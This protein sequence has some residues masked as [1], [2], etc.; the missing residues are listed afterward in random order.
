[1]KTL[2][3]FDAVISKITYRRIF[4]FVAGI[5]ICYLFW[6]YR[7]EIMNFIIKIMKRKKYTT[8]VVI[9]DEITVKRVEQYIVA[10]KQFYKGIEHD[11]A[12][13]GMTDSTSIIYN[14]CKDLDSVGGYP[15][16]DTNFNVTGSVELASIECKEVKQPAPKEAQNK[17]QSDNNNQNKQSN[18]VDKNKPNDK[19][20]SKKDEKCETQILNVPDRKCI[21]LIEICCLMFQ[22]KNR[23]TRL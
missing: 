18:D 10:H 4:A 7:T 15:F 21:R 2:F 3:N 17:E 6:K 14:K 20:S 9:S 19:E 5:S 13:D 16:V 1:M 8:G 12:Y 11:L 22:P 23:T